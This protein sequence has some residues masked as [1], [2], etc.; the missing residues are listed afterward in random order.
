M[1]LG[2]SGDAKN[3]P[4][5]LHGS[6]AVRLVA[7]GA[8]DGYVPLGRGFSGYGVKLRSFV[9]VSDRQAP[10]AEAFADD[11]NVE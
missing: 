4:P 10:A 11:I 2:E 5:D 7:A 6:P 9:A 3:Y 8:H 1:K